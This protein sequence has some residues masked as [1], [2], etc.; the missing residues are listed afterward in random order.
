MR[1][2]WQ[3]AVHD[4]AA[5]VVW[6]MYMAL[7]HRRLTGFLKRAQHKKKLVFHILDITGQTS[8][9]LLCAAQPVAMPNRKF[10]VVATHG[11]VQCLLVY[12]GVA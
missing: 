3:S 6:Q 7:Y 9:T 11:A 12:P 10:Q 1:L 8:L 2:E 4:I 5:N